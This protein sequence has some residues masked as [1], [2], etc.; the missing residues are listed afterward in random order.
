MNTKEKATKNILDFLR[1]DNKVLLLTGTHQSE[2]HSL[3]LSLILAEYP[4]PANI[5]FRANHSTNIKTF[6]SPVLELSKNPKTGKPIK[7]SGGYNLHVD[8][9][10]QMSWNSS[11]SDIDIAIVYPVGSLGESKGDDCVQDLIRRNAKK[12][13]LVS[14]IDNK[15]ISWVEQFNPVKVTYDSEEDDPNQHARIKEIV[16]E[17]NPISISGLP[18]YVK[19]TQREYLIQLYCKGCSSGRWAKLDKPYPGKTALK[20]AQIGE[21]TATCLKC[22]YENDDNYN[23]Y[24]R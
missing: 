3:A 11:P 16:S 13:V 1:S 24:E 12:I 15:D 10:N 23:W 4:S 14:Y 22:G 21:Y 18:Q 17:S 20:N 8:T 19:N 2:K 7:I 6:L 5:L 9:I